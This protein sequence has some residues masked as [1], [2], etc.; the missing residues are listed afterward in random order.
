MKIERTCPI[1]GKSYQADSHRLKIGRQTTCSLTCSYKF[2]AEQ[3]STRVT[4]TCSVCGK[5]FDRA[6]SHV[7]SKHEGVYC[8]TECQYK[9]RSLGLT[10]RIVSESYTITTEGRKAQA[11]ARK[12][13][14]A[15]RKQNG[16]YWHTEAT[17]R[18]LRH[19]TSAAIASGK[20]SR[21]SKIEYE[22]AKALSAIGID[23]IHQYGLREAATGRY[24]ACLDFF[25]PDLGIAIEVN[26]TYWHADPRFYDRSHLS[27]SQVRTTERYAVK[28]DLLR[29]LG[30]PLVEIWEHDIK[31]SVENAVTQ[32]LGTFAA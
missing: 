27:Q 25:L 29:E 8:S 11:E 4:L 28:V 15:T 22:V 14:V 19:K 32:A 1:C 12:R 24:V 5:K 20:F 26:G 23:A 9:G 30:I 3:L 17:K 6:P 10:E 21:V 16:T 7:K 2:R 18:E 13:A 31:Q